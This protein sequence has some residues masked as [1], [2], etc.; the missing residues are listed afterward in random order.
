MAYRH[1]HLNTDDE[2][3]LWLTFD[4]EGASANTL[5]RD[6]LTELD[7]IVEKIISDQPKGVV[8]CSGKKKGFIAGADI[9]QFVKLKTVQEAF[10]LIRQAQIIFDKWEALPMPT[11][12]MISGFC[13]GGGTEFALACRYRIAD[14]EHETKI[15]LPEVKLGIH[16]GWGGT[17]RLPRLIGAPKAM[18]V[19]LTGSALSARAAKRLGLVDVVV[20]RRQIIHAAKAYAL[21]PPKPHKATFLER[22]TNNI[23]VRPLLAQ[24]FYKQL[25]QKIQKAHY[26]APFAIVHNWLR[27]GAKGS[28]AMENEA[29]SIAELML[30][31]QARHLVRVFFLQEQLKGLAKGHHFSPKRVHVIGAGTMGGDIAAWCAF[32]GFRV[33]LQDQTA[34]QISPAIK[35]AHKL[36]KKKLKEP[37]L[38]QAAMDRLQPDVSG[39]AVVS[40]DVVIEAIFENLEVKQKIFKSIEPKLKSNALLASNTSSIPLDEI[41]TVLNNPERL[42]GIH[43]FNPVALMPLVEVVHSDKS[44]PEIVKQA[45]SFVGKMGKL[46]L[47]V[48]SRPGFLVNRVLMPYLMEAMEL[49]KEG[50]SPEAIDKAALN[51]GMPMGPVTLADKV[52]L[53]VC[54]SVAENLTAHLG[55]TVPE[56]LKQIVA[57]GRL[58]IKSGR[59]FYEYKNG[60]PIKKS[61]ASR[62]P[63]DIIDRLILRMANE[64]VAAL[65]EGIVDDANLLDAGMIFGTGF[66][67]FRGGIFAYL[68]ERGFEAAHKELSALAH[69]Y[70]DRFK[71]VSG[72]S[73]L[74]ANAK[75][76]KEQ[77]YDS[78]T[79]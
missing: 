48:L 65:S 32:R 58:G 22:F 67:P 6:V 30:T 28:R 73:Q 61:S 49:L 60:K 75:N 34:E 56:R 35:R 20:P 41:S 40:A 52:G 10:D 12:A 43:F 23:L 13:M 59:G 68:K 78:F 27:D 72:W 53:D 8:L 74:L 33:T 18:S 14:E 51:F 37:R 57:E 55:G 15:A 66:A 25:R 1:W 24:I 39:N 9:T 42:V 19:M 5:S 50:I 17:V 54:L 2:G 76:S 21:N 64:A 46:P 45:Q 4:R 29:K 63:A 69:R 44:A 38:I 16:P 47:P 7:D 71:P 3:V 62:E 11:I 31:S 79:E 70:G 36:F 77:Q 26:P